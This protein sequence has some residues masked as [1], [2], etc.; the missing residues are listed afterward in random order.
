[1][2]KALREIA[3]ENIKQQRALAG[4]TQVELAKKAKLADVYIS[5][6]EQN[7]KNIALDSVEQIADALAVPVASLIETSR[8]EIPRPAA[9][10]VKAL[11]HAVRVLEAYIEAIENE[12]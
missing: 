5:R 8:R 7:A 3:A 10:T 11:R 4:L 12:A 1:M 2:R 6:I 9:G